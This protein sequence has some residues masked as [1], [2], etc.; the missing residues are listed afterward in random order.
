MKKKFCKKKK[1]TVD[2]KYKPIN[3]SA[4]QWNKTVKHDM[5]KSCHW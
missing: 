2:K 4:W 3:I 5:H 1:A